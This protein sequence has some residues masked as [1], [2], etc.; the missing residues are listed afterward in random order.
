VPRKVEGVWKQPNRRRQI[1]L[2]AT[3]LLLGIWFRFDVPFSG[4]GVAADSASTPPPATCGQPV[5]A[6]G[7]ATAD[8]VRVSLLT[9]DVAVDAATP[10]AAEVTILAALSVAL[11][12]EDAARFDRTDFVLGTCDGQTVTATVVDPSLVELEPAPSPAS[13]SVHF[14]LASGST[15]ISLTIVVHSPNRT[16]GTIT[17]PLRTCQGGAAGASARGGDGLPGASAGN[18]GTAPTPIPTPWPNPT[19]EVICPDEA[20]S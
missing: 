13:G 15:P 10:S 6:W 4:A 19:A 12:S 8:G 9:I 5:D 7:A 16:P 1:S 14:R 20:A 3:L 17:F 2:A 18:Q 11:T